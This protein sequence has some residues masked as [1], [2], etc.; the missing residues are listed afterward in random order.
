[1]PRNRNLTFSTEHIKS[2]H[3]LELLLQA[4]VKQVNYNV[5][6]VFRTNVVF[7]IFRAVMRTQRFATKVAFEKTIK[8]K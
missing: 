7:P 8:Q 1:M 2:I 3:D 5:A 6:S 4:A